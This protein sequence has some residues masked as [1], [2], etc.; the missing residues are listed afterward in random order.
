MDEVYREL[1]SCIVESYRDRK[2]V[3]FRDDE[4]Q[5]FLAEWLVKVDPA[6]VVSEEVGAVLGRGALSEL[7]E[8]CTS[9]K[10][11]SERKFGFGSGENE[12]MVILNAPRMVTQIE[13]RLFKEESIKLLKR[14]MKAIEVNYEL[15]YITNMI[16]CEIGGSS[17][18]PSNMFNNCERILNREIESIKP[19]IVIVMGEILPLQKAINESS[20]VWWY[21]TE[22]PLTLIKNPEFKAEAWTTLKLVKTKMNELGMS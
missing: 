4:E 7:I 20:G 9:C 13:K 10:N 5:R 8:N 3:L 6:D 17:N 18:R 21:N 2:L 1:G 11:V 22:H 19:A 16:K 14:M 12:I 15:C